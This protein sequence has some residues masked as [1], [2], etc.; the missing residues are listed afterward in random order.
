MVTT[1]SIAGGDT[2]EPLN[3]QKRV[4]IVRRVLVGAAGELTGRTLLDCGCGAGAYARAYAQLGARVV[5]IEFNRDKLA[6]SMEAASRGLQLAVG[7]L[8]RLPLRDASV[9]AAVFNEVLEH[10]PDDIA[11]LREARRVLRPDGRLVVLS[12]NRLYPFESHGVA[13]KASGRPLPV[14]TPFVPYVPVRL[15]E[16]FLTYWARNYFPW[17][18]QQRVLSAGFAL[19]ETGFVAQT[20]ENVTGRQTGLLRRASPALRALTSWAEARPG[21]RALASVSQLIVARP[22]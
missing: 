5:G 1:V 8:E 9:D 16:R 12:P 22:R 17:T 15:G 6:R 2:A 10:V 20:F 19:L 3:L 13:L 21:L 4:A 14:Y 7:D 11:A 18:L